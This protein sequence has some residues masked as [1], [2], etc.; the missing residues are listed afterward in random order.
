LIAIA[1]MVSWYQPLLLSSPQSM[2]WMALLYQALPGRARRNEERKQKFYFVIL[3]KLKLF[4][5]KKLSNG[6]K[7]K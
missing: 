1:G 2:W 7:R 6:T 5:P 3:V 4:T